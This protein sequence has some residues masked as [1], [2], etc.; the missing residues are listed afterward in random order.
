M[1]LH[2]IL[3][4]CVT[5]LALICLVMVALTVL[6]HVEGHHTIRGV[7]L[8]LSDVSVRPQAEIPFTITLHAQSTTG[9][10]YTLRSIRFVVDFDD[11]ISG[12]RPEY[13]ISVDV[14]AEQG[15]EFVVPVEPG[16]V[17]GDDEIVEAMSG[18]GLHRWSVSGSAVIQPF[19]GRESPDIDFSITGVERR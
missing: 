13:E 11:F 5:P 2:R 12:A 18:A 3:V 1:R 14:P 4:I 8:S 9:Y 6:W 19:R 10:P 15:S 16:S 17:F 7:K